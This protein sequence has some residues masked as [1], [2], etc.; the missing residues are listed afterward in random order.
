MP[1][2]TDKTGARA[3]INCAYPEIDTETGE[4]TLAEESCART[5]YTI[6]K[7]DVDPHDVVDEYRDADSVSDIVVCHHVLTA[8]NVDD[9]EH[10]TK[11]ALGL[12]SYTALRKDG[13]I[14]IEP[15]RDVHTY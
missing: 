3:L 10:P 14:R 5:G 8:R 4:V 2:N 1:E 12:E 9:R 15:S 6:L 7:E 11:R 13:D